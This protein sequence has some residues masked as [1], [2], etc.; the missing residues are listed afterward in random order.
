MKKL[1]FVSILLVVGVLFTA[2]GGAGSPGSGDDGYG[3]NT[4]SS[5]GD[6]GNNDNSDDSGSGSSSSSSSSKKKRTLPTTTDNPWKDFNFELF[7]KSDCE[8]DI[9]PPNTGGA[10]RFTIPE[11]SWKFSEIN[12]YSAKSTNYYYYE[13][14]KDSEGNREITKYVLIWARKVTD[15]DIEK[16]ETCSDIDFERYYIPDTYRTSS[17]GYY[18]NDHVWIEIEVFEGADKI[19]Q[20]SLRFTD[21]GTYVTD[22]GDPTEFKRNEDTS[23]IYYD[24]WRHDYKFWYEKIK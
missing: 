7:P 17:Y 2:C 15:E 9:E 11:G 19:D 1:I 18:L 5:T 22:I 13:F 8:I 21:A 16:M 14:T 23:K 4:S 6:D 24:L 3:N 10:Y 20:T 12:E